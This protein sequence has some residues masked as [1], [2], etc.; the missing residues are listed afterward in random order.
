MTYEGGNN[1]SANS[2]ATG[3]QTTD[4]IQAWA[5]D[6]RL[7]YLFADQRKTRWTEEF[8]AATGDS[9]RGISNSTLNGNQPNTRDNGFN[10]FGLLNTGLAFAPA[11]SNVMILRERHYELS[12]AGFAGAF[13]KLQLG[14]RG[15]AAL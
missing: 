7:D 1:L 5:A 3:G 6:A 2:V 9:D 14:K 4:P 12:V 10:A 11:V 8:I 15:F 13:N